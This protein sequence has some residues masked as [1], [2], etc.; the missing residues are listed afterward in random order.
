MK[1]T[2]LPL[3]GKPVLLV[4]PRSRLR[5]WPSALLLLPFFAMLTL[6]CLAP[7][8]WVLINSMHSEQGLSLAN[9]SG[10]LS[11]PFYR[12]AFD[13]SLRISLWS[14]V[15]G[16]VISLL[17]A[18]SL[19][20]VSGG[21]RRLVVSITNMTSNLTGV[22]LAFA[23][24]ILVGTNGALTLLLRQWGLIE[25]FR[26]YSSNG[27]ILI[28]TYFQIPLGVLL[29]YPAFDSLDDD[30]QAA[31][32]LLGARLWQY[33]RYVGLPVLAPA[34]LGTFILLFANAIGA[35]A[36]A[37]ALTQGN[38]NLITVRIAS[39]VS[40]DIFLEPNMAAAL[41]VLLMLL[42]LLV[43]AVNQWLLKKGARHAR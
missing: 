21:L 22:P 39:L 11:S 1:T 8:V 20:R 23:F 17:G 37:Y 9:Y 18:A 13:N 29:L 4:R 15:I 2:S 19:R 36:S 35:Y 25:D 6:F 34:I 30:W 7:M 14:S 43:T 16:L 27:L 24:I 38:F 31:A 28:Y 42:L 10:I 32:S 12:Q 26:L 40:G 3:A 33:W 41:S 5:H